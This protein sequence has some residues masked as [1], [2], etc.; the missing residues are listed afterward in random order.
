MLVIPA[1]D[2]K[3]GH[4]VRL[5]QGRMAEETV[6]SANPAAVAERWEAAGAEWIHVVDLDGAAAGVRVNADAVRAIRQAVSLPLQL[7]G[8]IRDM[9][10]IEDWLNA[11]IDR[12]ILG[13]AACEN[14]TLVT[15]ACGQFAGK[16]AV[17]IDTRDGTVM[18]RGW[19]RAT[20]RRAVEMAAEMQERGASVVIVT[21]ISRDGMRTGINL[22]QTRDVAEAITVPVI[23]SGGVATLDDIRS[24]KELSSA[25][26]IGVI[27]GRA[28][29]DGSLDLGE[30]IR[31]MRED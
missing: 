25:G 15:E 2:V 23:A 6:Y 28:L 19:Q 21:D 3:K 5:R 17:G 16:I 14:P 13:T 7:G 10:A 31:V 8:G 26:V 4:C 24:I 1:I 29:Y 27:T 12:V 22:D 30:A 11:G 20:A 9:G 18:V